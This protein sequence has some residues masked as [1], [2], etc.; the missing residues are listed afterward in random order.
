VKEKL[1]EMYGTFLKRVEAFGEIVV[2]KRGA[3]TT[4]HQ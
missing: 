4:K 2:L 3:A 1:H